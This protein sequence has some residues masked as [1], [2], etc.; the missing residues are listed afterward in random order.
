MS[1]IKSLDVLEKILFSLYKY[2]YSPTPCENESGDCIYPG[3]LYVSYYEVYT[4]YAL[5]RWQNNH[6]ISVLEARC[7]PR[8]VRYVKFDMQSF[9]FCYVNLAS[10]CFFIKKIFISATQIYLK[11]FFYMLH[12]DGVEI[13]FWQVWFKWGFIQRVFRHFFEE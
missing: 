7:R 10:S 1:I 9:G 3:K 13:V 12:S 8:K 6:C 2:Y 5:A 4:K 11:N